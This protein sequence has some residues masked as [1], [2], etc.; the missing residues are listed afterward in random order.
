M[1]MV[2][3]SNGGTNTTGNFTL[4]VGQSKTVT[5]GS[6]PKCLYMYF[7]ST[8]QG[9]PMGC[10]WIFDKTFS[11]SNIYSLTVF[12]AS[13]TGYYDVFVSGT[14]HPRLAITLTLTSSGFT[15]LNGQAI[16]GTFYYIAS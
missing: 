1:P 3:V 13:S 9:S 4:N 2:R 14:S 6:S 5:I 7:D 8:F 15:V 10:S 12:S 11:T 16:S